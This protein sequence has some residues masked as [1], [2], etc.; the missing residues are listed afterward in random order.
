MEFTLSSRTRGLLIQIRE[1]IFQL[2]GWEIGWEIRPVC[3]ESTSLSYCCVSR[4]Y[5]SKSPKTGRWEIK[6]RTF[7]IVICLF[8]SNFVIVQSK[9]KAYRK[10][11]QQMKKNV[12]L[13]AKPIGDIK[14]VF[15]IPAYQRDDTC[16]EIHQERPHA[17]GQ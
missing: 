17:Y 10:K 6:T 2:K 9:H 5:G 8:F 12:I 4:N 16:R 1:A 3:G 11:H 13:E 7:K 15:N 14:G